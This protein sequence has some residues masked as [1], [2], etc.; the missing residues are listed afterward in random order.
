MSASERPAGKRFGVID[1]VIARAAAVTAPIAVR[2]PLLRSRVLDERVGGRVLI[3]PESLQH[4]GSFKFRAAYFRV[5]ELSAEER[6]RGV[7]TY[8]SGN[9][10]KAVAAAGKLLGA[11]VTIVVPSDA[12]MTKVQGARALGAT[13]VI[14]EHGSE[15]REAAANRLASRVAQEQGAVRLHPFEDELLLAG[16]AAMIRELLQQVV[17]LRAERGVS[18]DIDAV[19]QLVVPCGGGGLAAAACLALRGAARPPQICAVE[20]LGFDGLGRSL[21]AAARTRAAGDRATSCDALQALEP[22][23]LA[24]AAIA[25]SRAAVRAVAVSDAEV[26]AAQRFA[27]LELKLVLEPSA[28]TGLAALLG[29][30]AAASGRTSALV[31]T[32]GNIDAA[33]LARALGPQ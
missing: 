23:E 25:E 11:P 32:G 1:G 20:P 12:P 3:K 24:F 8:S 4:T 17:E 18:G 19:A 6:R 14:S 28:A 26:M 30:Q 31:L 7:V 22:G 21:A 13:I 33:A 2:T 29:G 27:A 16:H 9:F 15:N 5:S 10:G